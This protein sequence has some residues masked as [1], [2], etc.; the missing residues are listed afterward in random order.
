MITVTAVR[1]SHFITSGSLFML[2]QAVSVLRI[3][4]SQLRVAM[5]IPRV[6]SFR[7][8]MIRKAKIVIRIEETVIRKGERQ[9]SILTIVTCNL[10]RSIYNENTGLRSTNI[11]V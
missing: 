11:V 1:I 4:G 10:L 8:R 6:T 7:L 5:S 9:L 2:Q 3:T